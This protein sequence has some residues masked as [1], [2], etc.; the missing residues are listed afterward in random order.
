MGVSKHALAQSSK[1]EFTV[2]QDMDLLIDYLH[3]IDALQVKCGSC[4][5]NSE[6]RHRH[7]LRK[8]VCF[9]AETDWGSL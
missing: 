6:G 4:G 5:S 8:W 1:F 2:S 3:K 7:E 9:A